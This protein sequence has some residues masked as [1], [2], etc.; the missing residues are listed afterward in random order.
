MSAKRQGTIETRKVNGDDFT[1]TV[2]VDDDQI[3]K[4]SPPTS[5]HILNACIA[6]FS[7]RMGSL[8]VE[9]AS[10]HNVM[11]Q[12][13]NDVDGFIQELGLECLAERST[14]PISCG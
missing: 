12:R 6:K 11:I 14:A 3:T 2:F 10:D 1:V 8:P 5:G 9:V 7:D 13:L 4:P